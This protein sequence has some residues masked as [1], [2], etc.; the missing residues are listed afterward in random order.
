[1][2]GLDNFSF[3]LSSKPS[4][5]YW[6]QI[7]TLLINCLLDDKVNY[8]LLYVGFYLFV[9]FFEHFELSYDKKVR[10]PF[11][12]FGKIVEC[13]LTKQVRPQ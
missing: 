3:P 12:R 2:N 13:P 7:V 6:M 1:M 8:L 10:K 9:L 11:L 4:L 5:D